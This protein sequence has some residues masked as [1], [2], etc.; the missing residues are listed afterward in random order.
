MA[1]AVRNFSVLSYG[2]DFSLWH[3]LAQGTPAIT[4]NTLAEV[5]TPGFFDAAADMPNVGDMI[6]VSA[7]DDGALLYVTSVSG[8]VTT[9]MMSRTP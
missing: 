5:L 4:K 8:G 7:G 9:K 6:M 3:Y 1:F 2:N